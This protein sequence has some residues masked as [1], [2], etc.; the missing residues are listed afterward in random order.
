[1]IGK[2]IKLAI[3]C[4]LFTAFTLM[5][6]LTVNNWITPKSYHND[7]WSYSSTFEGFYKL[8]KN[9]VDVLFMGS[10][11]AA[12]SFNPQVIYDEYGITSYNLGCPQ[13][14]VF[15]TYYWLREAL[16]YQSPQVLV[17]ETNTFHK[18]KDAYVYNYFNCS[19]ASLRKAFDSM[20]FSPLKIE[21]A[22]KIE[23]VDPSQSAL[24]YFLMNIRYHSR[25]TNLSESDYSQKALAAHGAM[26]GYVIV[27]GSQKDAEDVTFSTE[28]LDSVNAEPMAE[29][30]EDYLGKIV[31]LC[32]QKNIKLVFAKI[33]SLE[34]IGRY[35][36]VEE[37]AK[38]YSIPFYDFNE[39][40]KYKEAGYS[41]EDLYGHLNYNGAAKISRYLGER[42][43][44]DYGVKPREDRSFEKSGEYYRN[45][46]KNIRLKEATDVRE[47]LKLAND[48]RYSI[49]LFAP[50]RYSDYIDDGIMKLLYELG[51]KTDLSKQDEDSHYCAI[52]DAG[53]VIEKFTDDDFN[54]YGS[55]RGGKTIYSFTVNT[56]I[57]LDAYQ[58]FSM[59]IGG[60]ECGERSNGLI[61]AVYDNEQMTIIDRVKVDTTTK[62]CT[63]THY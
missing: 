2:R 13:Q 6:V 35:K 60:T 56:G 58:T 16:K 63:L 24:S 26:K 50:L 9:S 47:Y 61:I 57:M 5:A 31:E 19:E 29:V 25:W 8:E 34:P 45:R 55:I 51:F 40:T 32:K 37:F 54:F 17:L 42:F 46:L 43:L 7:M 23:E 18:Y 30:T 59:N 28:D 21:L 49:F 4:I 20:K 44:N 52:K 1:M 39:E 14:S 62:E 41:A 33:P 3:K 10:S 22:R 27:D 38:Q 12:T 48:D 11:H 15:T 53:E 36:A